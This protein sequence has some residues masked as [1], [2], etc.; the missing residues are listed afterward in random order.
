MQVPEY[1]DIRGQK[2]GHGTESPTTYKIN[3]KPTTDLDVK[4]TSLKLLENSTGET[5]GI[6]ARESALKRDPKHN[7]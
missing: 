3:S 6:Q 2:G 4:C 1:V 7:P 5:L